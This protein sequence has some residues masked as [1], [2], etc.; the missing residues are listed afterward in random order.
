MRLHIVA[1]VSLLAGACGVGM[2]QQDTLDVSQYSAE[3]AACV[4]MFAPDKGNIDRC[5]AADR[6][7]WLQKWSAEGGPFQ[8]GAPE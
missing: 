6:A 1:L 2:S 8:D 3:Q 4:A 5:R 7:K